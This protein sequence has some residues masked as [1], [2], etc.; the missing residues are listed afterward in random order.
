ML[1]VWL[2]PAA[3]AADQRPAKGK[4][5]VAT[6]VVRGEAFAKTVVLLLHYDENG[7]AGIVVNRGDDLED[8]R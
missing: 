8:T 7:A 2:L 1:V 5:L 3:L 4:L 6:E